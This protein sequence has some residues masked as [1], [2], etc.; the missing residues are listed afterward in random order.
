VESS[1]LIDGMVMKR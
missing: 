1:E